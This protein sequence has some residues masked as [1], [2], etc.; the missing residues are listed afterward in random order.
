[1]VVCEN[2]ELIVTN[3]QKRRRNSTTPIS[4][5]M[6]IELSTS[7]RITRSSITKVFYDKKLLDRDNSVLKYSSG[8][9]QKT[10]N[11]MVDSN[12]ITP[13]IRFSMKERSE[14]VSRTIILTRSMLASK[15]KEN[16]S[17]ENQFQ[18]EETEL[19]YVKPTISLTSMSLFENFESV[20]S[21]NKTK[22]NKLNTADVLSTNSIKNEV[23]NISDGPESSSGDVVI[24][25]KKQQKLKKIAFSPEKDLEIVILDL[26]T[27][28]LFP[29]RH[30]VIE[31]G[32]VI[33]SMRTNQIIRT[34]QSLCQCNQKVPKAVTNLT[35]F[36]LNRLLLL[37]L[38]LLLL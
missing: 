31:V 17:V 10:D 27:T 28:G 7:K 8:K 1:M 37:L 13:K 38:L 24:I 5:M 18:D 11:S 6:G 32:A 3:L 20:R 12:P 33:V 35:G 2:S 4:K 15:E 21:L 29:S 36:I 9:K 23:I 16:I 22:N 25:E 14:L 34:Y 19:P 30:R 26:E